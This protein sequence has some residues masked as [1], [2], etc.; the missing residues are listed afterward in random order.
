MKRKEGGRRVTFTAVFER[1]GKWHVGYI[2]E[3]P[4]V[5]AQESTL[6]AARR[7]LKL[8]VRELAELNP[9]QVFGSRRKTEKLEVE[10]VAAPR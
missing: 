10:L 9:D 3:L 2:P 4:G 8:A 6:A 1:H 7:S 5:H